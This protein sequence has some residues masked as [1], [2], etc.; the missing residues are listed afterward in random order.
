MLD[1]LHLDSGSPQ[2]LDLV[3]AGA[4]VGDDRVDPGGGKAVLP[5]LELSHTMTTC[6]AASTSAALMAASPSC[7]A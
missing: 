5:S 7:C 2:G 6:S 3:G 1:Q 4:V